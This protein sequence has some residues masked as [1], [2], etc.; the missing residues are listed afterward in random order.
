MG[1][2]DQILTENYPTG[3]QEK[4]LAS[5]CSLLYWSSEA[6]KLGPGN[7]KCR[8]VLLIS[9]HECV[10]HRPLKVVSHHKILSSSFW[11]IGMGFERSMD[12]F[13]PSLTK[14]NEA[15]SMFL[16]KQQI[17]CITVTRKWNNECYLPGILAWNKN[18]M[19]LFFF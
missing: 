8:R 13:I 3:L 17:W 7:C 6:K 18:T 16:Q 10:C 2:K 15:L 5:F 4:N 19:N 1:W 12:A 9:A 11:L 14:S